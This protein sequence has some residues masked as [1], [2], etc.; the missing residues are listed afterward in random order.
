MK[1]MSGVKLMMKEKID[2]KK[3]IANIGPAYQRK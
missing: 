3:D 1:G 2:Q